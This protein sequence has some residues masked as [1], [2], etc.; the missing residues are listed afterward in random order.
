MEM[1]SSFLRGSK[2][3]GTGP[4]PGSGCLGPACPSAKFWRS[5]CS[6]AASWG[7]ASVKKGTWAALSQSG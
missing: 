1:A 6:S 2:A 4:W 7:S 5:S 3:S